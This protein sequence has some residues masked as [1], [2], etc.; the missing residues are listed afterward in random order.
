[1]ETTDFDVVIVGGSYAGLSAAMA[2]GRA[3]RRV[4]LVDSGQSCNRQ[5]PHSHNLITQDGA[6]PAH[7]T[8]LAKAQVLAYP[9][10]RF[11]VGT[12]SAVTGETNAFAV[13]TA[14]GER[15]QA[16]KILFTTGV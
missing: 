5:T 6:T 11:Q 16:R 1:M 10:V 8:A 3:V 4:L 13:E 7:L 14:A 12:V 15:F 2:L 9:T